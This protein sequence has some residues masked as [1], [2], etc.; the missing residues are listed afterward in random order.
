LFTVLGWR[1]APENLRKASI[2]LIIPL[3]AVTYL[4]GKF[5]E[6]RQLDAYIPLAIAFGICTLRP[7]MQMRALAHHNTHS[8]EAQTEGP[9]RRLIK[10]PRDVR[11][12]L[13]SSALFVR[14]TTWLQSFSAARLRL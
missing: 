7:A 10:K 14:E 2:A 9:A 11:G 6:P 3:L 5:R 1:A 13:V 8:F 4:F 12:A